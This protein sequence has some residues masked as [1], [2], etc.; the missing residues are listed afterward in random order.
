MH[1]LK[2]PE[3][4]ADQVIRNIEHLNKLL[5][6]YSRSYDN[7]FLFDNNN[8]YAS[9]KAKFLDYLRYKRNIDEK[10][11]IVADR[12]LTI[13]GTFYKDIR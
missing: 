5:K 13:L 6:D 12:Y 1:L 8:V 9:Y 7:F 2:K 10:N 4:K 3:E 11:V